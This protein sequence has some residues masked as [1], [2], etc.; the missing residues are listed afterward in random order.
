[1]V[2]VA[3]LATYGYTAS[4][5]ER[6][7]V[8]SGA[9]PGAEPIVAVP[10]EFR[11]LVVVQNN[12]PRLS[13]KVRALAGHRVRIIGYMAHLELAPKGGFYLAPM[14]VHSDESAAGVGDLP[15]ESVLVLSRTVGAQ[16]F[17]AEDGPVEV[18]GT[19][20]VGPEED[21]EGRANWLRITLD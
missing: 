14:P 21:S 19:L 17:P 1:M 13:E 3:S 12:R 2:A 9:N 6:V 16:P 18:A 20:A 8:E 4:R 7:I 11:D 15:L 5:S 10:L